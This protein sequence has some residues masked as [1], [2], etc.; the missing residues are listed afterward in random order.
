[1]KRTIP[2]LFAAILVT[3]SLASARVAT[4]S[5]ASVPVLLGLEPVRQDL[6]LSS[7]QC[8]LL[9]SLRSEYKARVGVISAVGLADAKAAPKAEAD[10]IA[11]R[12]KYNQRAVNVLNPSQQERLRQIERQQLGGRLLTS[13]AEQKALGLTVKQQGVIADIQKHEVAKAANIA[14]RFNSGKMT[15]FHRDIDLHRLQR[16]T[17]RSM[18]HVLTPDQLKQYLAL[19]GSKLRL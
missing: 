13:P 7:L 14:Q 9:D 2:L 17:S 1:M 11:L 15:P 6:K 4:D 3:A 5:P 19:Q 8:V 10:L 12:A 18:L 16:E